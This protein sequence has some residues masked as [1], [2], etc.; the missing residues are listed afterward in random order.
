MVTVMHANDAQANSEAAWLGIWISEYHSHHPILKGRSCKD[1]ADLRGDH[2]STSLDAQWKKTCMEG[3]NVLGEWCRDSS[4]GFSSTLVV[5]YGELMG[6]PGPISDRFSGWCNYSDLRMFKLRRWDDWGL[7]ID[8]WI[9]QISH[10]RTSEVIQW[11]N[12][13]SVLMLPCE[14]HVFSGMEFQN[15]FNILGWR[16]TLVSSQ[17][18]TRQ[19][20]ENN[21]PPKRGSTSF[22]ISCNPNYLDHKREWVQSWNRVQSRSLVSR[23]LSQSCGPE[24]AMNLPWTFQH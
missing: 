21:L 6:I 12:S 17:I 5:S 10:L 11:N 14:S 23:N 3:Q 13:D 19:L 8:E 4:R 22:I 2:G 16:W 7:W 24:S 20:T 9:I 15:S 1:G 18:L